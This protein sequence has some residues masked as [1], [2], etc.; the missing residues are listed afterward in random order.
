[1]KH[2]IVI[3]I[4][5]FFTTACSVQQSAG[6]AANESDLEKS[7]QQIVAEINHSYDVERIQYEY[8]GKPDPAENPN[9]T[10]RVSLYNIDSDEN[11]DVIGKKL[12]EKIYHTSEHTS[13]YGVIW[14]S[15]IDSWPNP[16]FRVFAKTRHLV[17]QADELM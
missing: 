2:L 3:P 10:I 4:L 9:S 6:N 14:V 1:M 11:K 7:M 13:Q 15:F 5:L 8:L 17:Y 16:Y 12:A